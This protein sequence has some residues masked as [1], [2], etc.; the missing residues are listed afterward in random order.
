VRY[1]DHTEPEPDSDEELKKII[2]QEV[3]DKIS[4][5]RLEFSSYLAGYVA[6]DNLEGLDE[7]LAEA[8]LSGID[9]A[10][11]IVAFFMGTGGDIK[12]PDFFKKAKIHKPSSYGYHNMSEEEQR[13]NG[14][15]IAETKALTVENDSQK[16]T[17]TLLS[18]TSTS[19]DDIID[20]EFT[21]I[22][23]DNK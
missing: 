7:A 22:L 5:R 15:A 21:E 13:A 1:L 2:L 20:T 4:T 16:V 3:M 6:G 9:D 11:R 18:L 12:N 19:D 23:F 14:L 10:N 17:I 8:Y